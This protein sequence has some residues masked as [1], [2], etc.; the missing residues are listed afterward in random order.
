M[1]DPK[2]DIKQF[3]V[4][5]EQAARA[6]LGSNLVPLAVGIALGLTAGFLI[7]HL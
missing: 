7:C 3:A 2:I 5:E 6:W 1:N 4:K